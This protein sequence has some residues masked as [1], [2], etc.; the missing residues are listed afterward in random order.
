MPSSTR[1]RNEPNVKFDMERTE[2]KEPET[3]KGAR[4]R[5]VLAGGDWLAGG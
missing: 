2:R 5:T 3:K 4:Q 1:N